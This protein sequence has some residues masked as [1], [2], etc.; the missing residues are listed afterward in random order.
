MMRDVYRI[1]VN[2][3]SYGRRIEA[4]NMIAFLIVILVVIFPT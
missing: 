2:G 3:D 1:N 4:L